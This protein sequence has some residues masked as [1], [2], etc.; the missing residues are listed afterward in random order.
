MLRAFMSLGVR[1]QGSSH[2]LPKLSGWYDQWDRWQ[3]QL[4][5][6]NSSSERCD[7]KLWLRTSPKRSFFRGNMAVKGSK[8]GRLGVNAGSFSSSWVRLQSH[9]ILGN[10]DRRSSSC[11]SGK[12]S[13]RREAMSSNG[14][15]ESNALSW[16]WR[17]ECSFALGGCWDSD[18]WTMETVPSLPDGWIC[19]LVCVSSCAF[20]RARV[21]GDGN[22]LVR[23][24]L[25]LEDMKIYDGIQGRWK[26]EDAS[27]HLLF[28][29]AFALYNKKERRRSDAIL[30]LVVCCCAAAMIIRQFLLSFQRS[31]GSTADNSWG[32][33]CEGKEQELCF[34]FFRLSSSTTN[35]NA[36]RR[37]QTSNW[38]ARTGFA[39]EKP[40]RILWKAK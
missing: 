26:E 9:S 19:E 5:E 31:K 29:F 7:E 3:Q 40:S 30:F 21:A 22:M 10:D 4:V 28:V 20:E 32:L 18:P 1:Q 8:D 2:G 34:V 25:L 37:Q 23:T 24:L 12:V 38:V 6:E 14:D 27:L 11:M 39:S 17:G 35:N 16:W 15:D 13:T 36:H 33:S